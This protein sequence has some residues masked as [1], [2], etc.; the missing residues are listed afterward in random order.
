M[1]HRK[2]NTRQKTAKHNPSSSPSE[3]K[4]SKLIQVGHISL[5]TGFDLLIFK[6]T[7]I[8]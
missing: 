3:E 1:T 5:D 4:F 2:K 8:C 6:G 7:P